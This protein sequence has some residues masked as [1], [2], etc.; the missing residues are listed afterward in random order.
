VNLFLLRHFESE[1][2]TANSISN[3]SNDEILTHH[4]RELCTEFAMNYKLFCEK[5]KISF[6]A[7]HCTDSTRAFETA[8][9]ISSQMMNI[10][11]KRYVSFKSIDAGELAGKSKEEVKLLAPSISHNYYLCK[12]GLLNVYC[13]NNNMNKETE[14]EFEKRIV[15]QFTEIISGNQNTLIIAH[16]SSIM[17]ILIYIARNAGIYPDN[18]Y[19]HIK[20][21]LGKISW[22]QYDGNIWN[23]KYIDEHIKEIYHG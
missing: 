8:Q 1:K 16:R 5:F 7:I 14:K 12:K 20:L 3:S 13:L 19:G 15:N 9:I 4:G 11:I 17:A 18:F 21:G 10:P 22:I 23:I 2:N 6:D